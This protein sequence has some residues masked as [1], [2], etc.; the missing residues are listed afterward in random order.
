M[1]LPANIIAE[2]RSQEGEFRR[3]E[4]PSGLDANTALGI[5]NAISASFVSGFRLVLFCCAGLSIGS[6]LIAAW[7]ITGAVPATFHSG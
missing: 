2:L 7:L 1:K 5:R 6:A 3:M 4:P